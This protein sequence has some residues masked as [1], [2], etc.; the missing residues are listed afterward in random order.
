MRV[1]GQ[2][3]TGVGAQRVSLMRGDGTTLPLCIRP[4]PLGFHRRLRSVGLVPPQPP[5]R[6]A[7]DAGGSPLRDAQGHAVT[8][9]DEGDAAYLAAVELYHQRVAVLAVAEALQGDP[10]VELASRPPVESSTEPTAWTGY[11][12][13]LFAELEAAGFTAGDLTQLCGL[14]CRMSRLLDEHLRETRGN[15]SQAGAA[16]TG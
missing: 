13:G 5:V 6:V 4:L 11:A 12:D 1:R 2:E 15:F 10:D 7:R 8:L 14:I 16:S 3:L 9:R